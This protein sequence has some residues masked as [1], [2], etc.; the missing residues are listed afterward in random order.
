MNASMSAKEKISVDYQC[1]INH[2]RH[3]NNLSSFGAF[4]R[5][6]RAGFNVKTDEPL[7]AGSMELVGQIWPVGLTL[8]TP[9]IV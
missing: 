4:G 5:R 3:K 6:T 9:N 1:A 7:W 8:L 2:A